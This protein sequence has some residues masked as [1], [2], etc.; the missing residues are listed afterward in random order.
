MNTGRHSKRYCLCRLSKRWHSWPPV[1]WRALPRRRSSAQGTE[2]GGRSS[3]ITAHIDDVCRDNLV[4][5]CCTKE[6]LMQL[7][8]PLLLWS[9]LPAELK[10]MRSIV[11]GKGD[12]DRATVN[13]N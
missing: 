1:R 11:A 2:L 10:P 7:Y 5:A 12:V 9:G 3:L 4:A 13:L 6:L 8:L